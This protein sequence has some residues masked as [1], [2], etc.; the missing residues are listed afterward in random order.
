MRTRGGRVLR[1]E[2]LEERM[3]LATYNGQASTA[4]LQENEEGTVA[5]LQSD[6][7][8]FSQVEF[9]ELSL[10]SD[11]PERFSIS[12]NYAGENLTLQLEKNSIFG[13]NT[14]ILVD[15][16][17]GDLIQID[18][19]IDRSY[20]GTVAEQ[21]DY[22]VSALLTP[23]GL[24]ATV[25]RPN[26]ASL[27]VEPTALALASESAGIVADGLTR[28]AVYEDEAS[29][30]VV[31]HDHLVSHDHDGDGVPD[32][33][34]EDHNDESGGGH[35]PGCLCASC[36][37]SGQD[38]S[39]SASSSPA[40]ENS[41]GSIEPL[42]TLPP[43]RVIDVREY[44]IGVEIGSDALMNNYTGATTQDKVDHAMSVAQSIPGNLDARFLRAAGIKHRLGTV[45][46]RTTSDPF[47]VL[48]GNDNTGLSN[49][50]N[51]WNNLQANEGIAPTHD[52][53]VYHVRGAP[54]GLA[55]V[56]SVG[57]SNRYALT[58]SN[59]PT[60]WAD[61]TLAHEFGHSWNLGHVPPG[62]ESSADFYE[63]RPRS[64]GSIA[65]GSDDFISIM[66]GSGTHNIGRLSS[67]ETNVVLNAKASKLS[68]GD[69]VSP[70]EVA[71]YGW[72]D[73]ATAAASPITIDVV[74]N[75][76][77]ANND[78]LDA[79]LRD[80][81]SF[82]GGTIS[83]SSE[84]GPGGRN[85]IIYT[86]PVGVTG[87]DFFHYT[88]VDSTG[89]TD[90]GAVYVDVTNPTVTVDLDAIQYNYDLGTT[91][92][93]VLTGGS[94][95]WVR[96]SHD[97]I[98]DI[99]WST[100]VNSRDRGSG[101]GQNAA[102]RDHVYG[103]SSA[104]LNHT[105]SNGTWAVVMNVGDAD[106]SG[107]DLDQMGIRAEGQ[108]I[109][110]N[111]TAP[112]GQISYVTAAGDSPTPGSFH[113]KVTDGELNLEIF[114]SGTPDDWNVTRISLT[115]IAEAATTIDLEQTEYKYDLGT[116][117]SPVFDSTYIRL[118][119]T[120]SGDITWTGAIASADRDSAA[121]TNDIN[122]DLIHS[123]SG[124]SALLEHAISDGIWQVLVNVGDRDNVRDDVGIRAEG[125]TYAS[126]ID[127]AA[128]EYNP[129]VVFQVPVEDGS[130]SLEFFDEGG[131][132]DDWS[133]TRIWLTRVGDLPTSAGP[134]DFNSDGQIDDD[135]L[136]QWQGD[137]GINGNS[138]AD[139][140]G[141]TTGFDFLSWQRNFGAGVTTT[142]THVDSALNNGSFEDHSGAT[143]LAVD[144]SAQRALSTG[145]TPATIPFWT[146]DASTGIGGWE[147]SD[148][149]VASDGTAYAFANDTADVTLTS[150]V[151]VSYLAVEGDEIAVEFD[152]GSSNG[153]PHQYEARLKF[154][155]V[156]HVLGSVTDTNTVSGSG[157]EALFARSFQ[158]T[159]GATDVG[160]SPV[161]E[162][163]MDNQGGVS[164][165]YLDN[166]VLSVS[167]IGS[168]PQE[169]TVAS[170]ETLATSLSM[171]SEQPTAGSQEEASDREIVAS[172][173]LKPVLVVSSPVVSP[174]AYVSSEPSPI[175]ASGGLERNFFVLPEARRRSEVRPVRSS[176]EV[177]DRVF[178][179]EE[180]LLLSDI[181][182]RY[183]SKLRSGFE[184]IDELSHEEI[185][186][187]RRSDRGLEI[188]FD[189]L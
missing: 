36:C 94:P 10:P 6:T 138:D 163:F 121:G 120:A 76:H 39:D 174:V 80:T 93:P 1:V 149:N 53:A 81:V 23:E 153:A 82:L 151:I 119:D 31:A 135:D 12:V 19:G 68:F 67:G 22:A 69:Q 18:P 43:T 118:T 87:S 61:G 54:S 21:P 60:S 42:S 85:E 89:R 126:N 13:E 166:I 16:G 169:S 66:H 108:L 124:N 98:G 144:E 52:L 165:S 116:L 152:T 17:S 34:P 145:G 63:A 107:F 9:I 157:A 185:E 187:D 38:V 47:T 154:G 88:V 143:G 77:D 57:S 130:L 170:D 50:R 91:D 106:G 102:N 56:N 32:H 72:V 8:F 14:R 179:S 64:N 181:G 159:V 92:S 20:L 58:A 90:W 139:G 45:I 33:A 158:Y 128:A 137:F 46:I 55:Y 173:V 156:T 133:I 178:E 30:Q 28:H 44:E 112:A 37:P 146:L 49:F 78:V 99:N 189:S 59:G 167:R 142:T 132:N 171:T 79:Q 125:V 150:A 114:D 164:K 26:Q 186:D 96:I 131:A 160:L 3:L 182:L 73:S 147:A 175:L 136:T 27:K 62:T 70:G 104:T 161:V 48:N 71:P 177:S 180:Q 141:L 11:L 122:R 113:V 188:V 183:S 129:N 24:I 51:Y 40:I 74:A 162:I 168:L 95:E 2:V 184:A 97:T 115:K 5:P 117:A 83:L 140:D 84:T 127:R 75:D 86:P 109:T 4:T 41:A 110:S 103:S 35:P 155:G 172:E 100:A 134:G 123:T 101:V 176:A 148:P 7:E 25:I 111:I 29:A 15:D 65:G 105:I